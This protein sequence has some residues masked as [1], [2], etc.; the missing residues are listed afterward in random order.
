MDL[1]DALDGLDG[2][3]RHELRLFMDSAPDAILV[4]DANGT[5]R[6]ANAAA[7]PLFGVDPA[8]LVGRLHEGL[9]P[10]RF[11][12]AHLAHRREYAAHPKHRLMGVGLDLFALRSD[13]TEIPVDVSLNSLGGRDGPLTIAFV[14]D[15]SERKRAERDAARLAQIERRRTQALEINDNV[16]QGLAA[17]L[18]ALEGADNET[19]LKLIDRTLHT[20]RGRIDELL[21][22]AGG[23]EVHAGDLVRQQPAQ[24]LPATESVGPTRVATEVEPGPV[25]VLIADD[26]DDIRMLLRARLGSDPDMVVVGE[27]GDGA[28]AIRR[29]E[30]L[31]PDVVVLD[32]AMPVMDG[33]EALPELRRHCPGAQV[34]VLTGFGTQSVKDQV[35]GLG[36]FACVEKGAKTQDLLA[37]ISAAADQGGVPARRRERGRPHG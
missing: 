1:S 26:S 37:V 11:R 2:S 5:I 7:G 10:E 27:A 15:A 28:E 30:E 32:L 14:R 29:A 20:A 17:A 21:Q 33:L 4:V 35:L 24:V 22:E 13:G 36:A 3:S 12:Q 25:R 16:V 6:Y 8:S 19:A 9:L 18:L 31:D 34:V 23:P